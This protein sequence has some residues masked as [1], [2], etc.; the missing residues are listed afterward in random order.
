MP[1]HT[2]NRSRGHDRL[3][4]PLVQAALLALWGNRR[5]EGSGY[6]KKAMY[7]ADMSENLN[8]HSTTRLLPLRFQAMVKSEVRAGC[9]RLEPVR[10]RVSMAETAFAPT[11]NGFQY[12][13]FPPPMRRCGWSINGPVADIPTFPGA[14]SHLRYVERP[15]I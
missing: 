7:F 8:R 1:D 13:R 6:A 4:A 2:A 14:R 11:C 12:V 9:K 15:I 10:Q 5:K 3:H